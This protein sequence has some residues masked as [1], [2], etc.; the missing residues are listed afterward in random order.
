MPVRLEVTHNGF[1]VVLVV[2]D[3]WTLNELACLYP[4]EQALFSKAEHKIH[5]LVDIRAMRTIPPGAL[6]KRNSPNLVHPNSGRLA[7]VGTTPVA[8]MLLEV[9]CKL[10]Y[11]D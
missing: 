9:A 1:I 6:S 3:P 8:R 10:A 5:T 11:Y 2:E 7:I 4:V